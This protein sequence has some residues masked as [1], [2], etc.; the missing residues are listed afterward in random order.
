MSLSSKLS[1]YLVER[2]DEVALAVED[3][4]ATTEDAVV[5]AALDAGDL[6]DGATLGRQVA[7]EETQAAGV[8]EGLVDLV[9]DVF[10]RCGRVQP[11]E[12]LGQGLAGAGQGVAVDE[13]RVEELRDDDLEPTL[14]VHVDHG[15]VPE[16]P[17][18]DQHGQAP[19]QLVEVVLAQH[20]GPQVEAGGA[21]DLD[22]V[23]QHV[24]RAA[25]GD[26]DR[27]GVADRLGRDD[28]AGADAPARHGEQAVDGL[29][30]EVGQ[31]ARI[32]RG[33]GHHVQRLEARAPR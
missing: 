18:V 4:G 11:A 27:H 1:G 32:V 28:V 31:A 10:V 5:D 8:L 6:Q 21:G 33:R 23:Q 22:A 16:R 13:A 25:H 29:V 14:G 24:G 19:G 9:D 17:H 3:A 26:G 7:A 12:L 2:V 20:V 15:V 30:R